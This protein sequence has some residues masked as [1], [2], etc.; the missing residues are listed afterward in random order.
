LQSEEKEKGI[1]EKW[2]KD[3]NSISNSSFLF[4]IIP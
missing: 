3:E 2:K 1:K 4:F